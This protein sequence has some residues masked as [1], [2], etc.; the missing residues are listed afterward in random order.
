METTEDNL[1]A[2]LTNLEKE[3]KVKLAEFQKNLTKE[4]LRAVDAISTAITNLKVRIRYEVASRERYWKE[5]EEKLS[6]DDFIVFWEDRLREEVLLRELPESEK[7]ESSLKAYKRNYWKIAEW[8][9]RAVINSMITNPTLEQG[10]RLEIE[11]AKE[12]Y[13]NR[14]SKLRKAPTRKNINLSE[15]SRLVVE[16]FEK[17]LDFEI[18]SREHYRKLYENELTDEEFSN[19]W[20]S[21]L[22]AEVFTS[23]TSKSA[24]D[25]VLADF[26]RFTEF[27]KKLAVWFF[28]NVNQPH[29]TSQQILGQV[30]HRL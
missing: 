19:L 21:E 16:I 4:S 3:H 8:N 20:D 11:Q 15:K 14:R 24:P 18:Q 28:S 2:E 29:V 10:L 25:L 26:P 13:R 22:R 30:G 17:F 27:F 12:K 23:L 1:K 9:F 6:R 5:F 7:M